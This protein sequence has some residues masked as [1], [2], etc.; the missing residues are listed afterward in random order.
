MNTHPVSDGT[1]TAGGDVYAGPWEVVS[2]VD[3]F[4]ANGSVINI[5]QC[6]KAEDGPYWSGSDY[7]TRAHQE[8]NARLISA[9]PDLYEALKQALIFIEGS[10]EFAVGHPS[11][12]GLSALVGR[13]IAK[14]E[15][16]SEGR[17]AFSLSDEADLDSAYYTPMTEGK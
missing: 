5:A 2:G 12:E 1:D 10:D 8:G 17:S 9:A 6:G 15:G 16:Q 7:S 13:A 11:A 4:S 3:V 14:A